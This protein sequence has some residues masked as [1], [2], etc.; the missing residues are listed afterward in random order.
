MCK[1]YRTIV[2]D[3]LT[4]RSPQSCDSALPHMAVVARALVLFA[5]PPSPPPS[6]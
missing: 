4:D 3:L 6:F 5:L 1:Q 2:Y